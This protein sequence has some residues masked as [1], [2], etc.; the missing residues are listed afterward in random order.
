MNTFAI[1]GMLYKIIPFLIW[2]RVYSTRIGLA[3]VPSLA[4]LYSARWQG[5][6]YWAYLA[7]LAAASFGI[8]SSN[9]LIVRLGCAALVLSLLTLIVNSGKMLSH[10]FRPQTGTVAAKPA[11]IRNPTIVAA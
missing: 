8:L 10:L 7:G 4:D 9:S 1:I 2:Y 11:L 5:I 6:G 3:K